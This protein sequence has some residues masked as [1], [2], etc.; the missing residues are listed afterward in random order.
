MSSGVKPSCDR[1]RFYDKSDLRSEET[2]YIVGLE[3][4]SLNEHNDDTKFTMEESLTELS[5][6]AGAAGL[7]VVGSTYQRVQKPSTEYYVGPGKSCILKP[8]ALQN[9]NGFR[10]RES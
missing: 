3:D 5:E 10:R 8:M 2:C 7:N 6:L 4:K 1:L 9:L